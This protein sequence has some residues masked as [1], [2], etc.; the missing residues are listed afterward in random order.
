MRIC[1]LGS[2]AG[3]GL[4]QW[5][6]RCENCQAA[7]TGSADVQPRT[8]S[9]VAIRCQNHAWFLLNA[10]ADIRQQIIN[11]PALH[12]PPQSRRGTNIAGCV[13]TD[14]EIDHTSGLLQLREGCTPSIFS[15]STVHRWLTQYFPV[16]TVLEHFANQPWNEIPLDKCYDLPLANGAPSGL[17]IQAFEVGR[18][19]PRFVP[20]STSDADGS[21]IG[22]LVQDTTTGGILVYAPGVATIS[23][24][25]TRVAKDADCILF[26][27]TFWTDDEPIRAGITQRTA[28]QMGHIPISGPDGSLNW[29]ANCS[30]RHRIYIHINNTNPMLNNRSQ[31]RHHVLQ[32]GIQIGMDGDI[33]DV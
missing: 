3:G 14:A 10:S 2:A 11:C 8:Q 28:R 21:V 33:Y 25:L 17:T 7:R 13:L 16:K 20:E 1:I 30:A 23:E 31:E 18:D 9:S 27:G 19:V 24:S 6:C 29:L 22:L 32:Q 5:N 12:P 4:P 26:D 15:T